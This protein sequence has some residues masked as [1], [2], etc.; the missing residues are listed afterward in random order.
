MTCL[1]HR[2]HR[3]AQSATHPA[4]ME[5]CPFWAGFRAFTQCA[6]SSNIT[7]P[8]L[9]TRYDSGVRNVERGSNCGLVR[10]PLLQPALKD[11][12]WQKLCL[13]RHL[14]GRHD[15]PSGAPSSRRRM[16]IIS[17]RPPTKRKGGFDR[18]RSKLPSPSVSERAGRFLPGLGR[19]L[20]RP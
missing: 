5:T 19:N 20:P 3:H 13:P 15:R 10:H 9:F 2:Q 7:F 6:A 12:V 18:V 16:E 14:N 8:R 1:P 11:K 17:M 4:N